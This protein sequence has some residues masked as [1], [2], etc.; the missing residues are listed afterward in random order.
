MDS[1]TLD[2]TTL[3]DLVRPLVGDADLDAETP[4]LSSGLLDSFGL[5]ELAARLAE[6]GVEVDLT[7]LGADNADTC[8]QLIGALAT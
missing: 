4:L 6:L 8:A 5:V 3:L 1:A 2:V 7:L